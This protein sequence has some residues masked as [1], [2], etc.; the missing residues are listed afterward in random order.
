LGYGLLWVGPKEPLLNYEWF[1]VPDIPLI[2]LRVFALTAIAAAALL[3]T[4]KFKK[5]V[6]VRNG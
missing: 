5:N 3:V 2:A 1:A 4:W 6:E